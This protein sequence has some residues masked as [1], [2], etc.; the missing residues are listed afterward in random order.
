MA[1]EALTATEYIKHHMAHLAS[2]HQGSVVD[3]SIV[4]Y[5]TIFSSVLMLVS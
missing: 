4:N 1:A 5:D 3:F 2:A